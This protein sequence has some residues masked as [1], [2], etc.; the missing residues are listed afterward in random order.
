MGL[1][2]TIQEK[3]IVGI[4]IAVVALGIVGYVFYWQSAAGVPLGSR[5]Y[6][7]VSSGELVP[8]KTDSMPPVTLPSGNQGVLAHV[9]ACGD[10]G[11]EQ[12]VGYLQKYTDAYKKQATQEIDLTNSTGPVTP[13]MSGDLVAQKPDGIGEPQWC[14]MTSLQGAQIV[15]NA[16]ARCDSGGDAKKAVPCLPK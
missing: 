16:R 4:I 6:Y 10:C 8:H 12:F 13:S 14:E 7:D 9:F 15:R 1:R 5:Y 2:E 3:P 11:S